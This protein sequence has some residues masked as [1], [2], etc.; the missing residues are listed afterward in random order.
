MVKIHTGV[1]ILGSLL[2]MGVTSVLAAPLATP[3]QPQEEGANS[4]AM[5]RVVDTEA[6]AIAGHS[7]RPAESVLDTNVVEMKVE[8]R[9]STEKKSKPKSASVYEVIQRQREEGRYTMES[10]LLINDRYFREMAR[11]IR[12][13]LESKKDTRLLKM[14]AGLRLNQ[15]EEDRK[16]QQTKEFLAFWFDGLAMSKKGAV[17]A[18]P[19][20]YKQENSPFHLDYLVLTKTVQLDDLAKPTTLAMFKTLM[21]EDFEEGLKQQKNAH[22]KERGEQCLENFRKHP[23]NA[24]TRRRFAWWWDVMANQGKVTAEAYDEEPGDDPATDSD[25]SRVSALGEHVGKG[26]GV[27]HEDSE[28]EVEGKGKGVSYGEEADHEGLKGK[29]VPS[30]SGSRD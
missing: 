10:L 7:S 14:M 20:E 16:N 29:G 27:L 18:K 8:R 26:K 28:E 11:I 3:V 17:R 1:V 23:D 5:T 19:D 13:R 21:I 22:T 24:D 12:N 4:V 6:S 2:Q 9:V 25:G 30:G 15:W